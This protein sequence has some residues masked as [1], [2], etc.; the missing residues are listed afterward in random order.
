MRRVEG[1]VADTLGPDGERCS[2]AA[3]A[4][5]GG[6]IPLRRSFET[7]LG[8]LRDVTKIPWQGGRGRKVV[9]VLIMDGVVVVVQSKHT[10][11]APP[12]ERWDLFPE[13]IHHVRTIDTTSVANNKLV[14]E[15]ETRRRKMMRSVQILTGPK[16]EGV[17]VRSCCCCH[18]GGMGWDGK[19]R[20]REP[21]P[22]PRGTN[23]GLTINL[24]RGVL[25]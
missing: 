16:V 14:H 24:G 13:R 3:A 9:V 20:R 8:E 10:L 22:Q 11:P 4:A 1:V 21:A 5:T 7:F 19:G 6:D 2:A 12:V 18:Q 15:R 23:E 17:G 25:E